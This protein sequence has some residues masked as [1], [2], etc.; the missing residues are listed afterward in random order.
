MSLPSLLLPGPVGLAV[1]PSSW[2][3]VKAGRSEALGGC[4]R[5]T[6]AAVLGAK[7][8]CHVRGACGAG[9]A[10]PSGAAR[11]GHALES[12]SQISQI[13]NPKSQAHRL[14]PKPQSEGP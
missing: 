10:A 2:T 7:S 12:Q 13:P 3:V 8:T 5:R 14:K 11:L 1:H 6:A 9:G 4:C